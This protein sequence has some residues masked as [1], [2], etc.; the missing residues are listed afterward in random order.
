VDIQA[1]ASQHEFHG[2]FV[3]DLEDSDSLHWGEGA[4]T[5]GARS[6]SFSGKLAP[7][8]DYQ[9]YLSPKFIETEKDF[10]QFKS[11]M[12]KVGPVKTFDRFLLDIPTHVNPKDYQ[13]V[14]IWCETFGEFITATTYS[15]R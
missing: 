13:T 14:I 11:Q 3:R 8:P 2:E 1:E 10:A 9:L 12:V 5:I 15:R 4:V 6:I 7:G